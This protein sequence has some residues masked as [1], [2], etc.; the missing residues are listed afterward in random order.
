[1]HEVILFLN[2]GLSSIKLTLFGLDLTERLSGVADAIG[3]KSR[4]RIGSEISWPELPMIAAT[5]GCDA[6]AFTAGIGENATNVRADILGRLGWL[7]A[8]VDPA[9]NETGDP[10]LHAQGSSL[11]AWVLPADED[12]EIARDAIGLLQRN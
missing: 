12:R 6:I 5:D 1:M 7:G 3:G 11:A 10:R 4:L 9:R 8:R 2:A